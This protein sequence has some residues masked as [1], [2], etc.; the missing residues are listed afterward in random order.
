VVDDGGLV[1]QDLLARE[2]GAQVIEDI[3]SDPAG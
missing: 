2:L 3:R 1:G